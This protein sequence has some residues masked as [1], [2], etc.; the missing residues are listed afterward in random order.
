M[1]PT[2][3]D[4]LSSPQALEDL[5]AINARFIHNFV[6]NDVASHDALLHPDFVSIQGD[7]GKLDRAAYLAQWST[8]FDPDVI[9]YWDTRDEH[10]TLVD[11]VALVRATNRFLVVRDGRSTEHVA[12]YTDTYVYLDGAWTC[13]QAQITPV[14]ER[15][16]PGE[17]TMVSV[18][19]A[20]VKQSGRAPVG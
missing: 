10:I 4:Y 18:Y 16:H 19:L 11:N 6:T 15:H 12:V 1:S 20:G 14:Q 8:G 7:G 17:D 13:L 3:T 9:P 5:R 2:E